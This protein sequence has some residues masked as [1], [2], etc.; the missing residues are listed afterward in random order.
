MQRSLEQRGR[1]PRDSPQSER[2]RGERLMLNGGAVWD[3]A[4]A[5]ADEE[6]KPVGGG[7]SSGVNNFFSVSWHLMELGKKSFALIS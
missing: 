2:R 3:D 1:A 7:R 5:D 6:L 4:D